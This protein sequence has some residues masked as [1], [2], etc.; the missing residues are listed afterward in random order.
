[1]KGKAAEG[2]SE[3]VE[4]FTTNLP[5]LLMSFFYDRLAFLAYLKFVFSSS[6]LVRKVLRDAHKKGIKFTVIV[7]DGRP[8]LEGEWYTE[9]LVGCI[10]IRLLSVCC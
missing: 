2:F 10:C 6:S 5:S 8:M 1:M 9:M 3:F 7:A 4:M